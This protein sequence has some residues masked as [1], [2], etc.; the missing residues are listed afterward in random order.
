MKSNTTSTVIAEQKEHKTKFGPGMTL[1]LVAAEDMKESH[2]KE[3][4]SLKL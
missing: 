1:S 2:G 4:M 3:G